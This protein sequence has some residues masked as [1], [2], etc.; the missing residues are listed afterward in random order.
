MDPENFNF[1]LNYYDCVGD[2]QQF[3]VEAAGATE[4]MAL[5]HFQDWRNPRPVHHLNSSVSVGSL[6]SACTS[7]GESSPESNRYSVEPADEHYSDT[8]VEIVG[9]KEVGDHDAETYFYIEDGD[10]GRSELEHYATVDESESQ[11]PPEDDDLLNIITET[12][13]KLESEPLQHPVMPSKEDIVAEKSQSSKHFQ[14]LACSRL[15]QNRGSLR[16]H[17][18]TKL[19]HDTVQKKKLLDP[20]YMTDTWLIKPVVCPGC[21]EHFQFYYQCVQHIYLKH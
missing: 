1:G 17:F 3:S 20:V 5:P 8:Y 19:H 11:L 6:D 18:N 15:F 16:K 13:T 2:P 7:Y 9:Y 4:E 12:I 10:Q 21:E 14:C